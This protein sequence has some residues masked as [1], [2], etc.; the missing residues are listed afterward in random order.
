[1]S[2]LA[3]NAVLFLLNKIWQELSYCWD[4]RTRVCR[5][6]PWFDAP[7]AAMLVVIVVAVNAKL[8]ALPTDVDGSKLRTDV[9]SCTAARRRSI[10][11]VVW[12]TTDMHRHS[13]GDRCDQC[14]V[15]TWYTADV[16]IHTAEG[17]AH[18]VLHSSSRQGPGWYSSCP[19]PDVADMPPASLSSLRL[20]NEPDVRH[21]ITS[22]PVKSCSLASPTQGRL[23]DS[24]K[25]AT[26]L[27][28][29]KKSGPDSADM[30]KFCPV[31]NRSFLSKWQKEY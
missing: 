17:S 15:A 11:L 6:A 24:Q 14:F 18:G 22:L 13:S 12:N 1:M 10:K 25:H 26:I 3:A 2:L 4:S 29:L 30:A 9:S 20:C 7:T 5:S 27:P 21:I 31:S 28:L 23:P 8:T 16:N 19:P